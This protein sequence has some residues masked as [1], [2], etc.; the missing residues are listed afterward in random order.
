M[1]KVRD[2]LQD[3]HTWTN[4]DYLALNVTILAIVV[5]S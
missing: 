2:W 5:L 4:L 1:R 3:T